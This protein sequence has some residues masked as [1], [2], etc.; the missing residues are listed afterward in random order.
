MRIFKKT[1][2]L[3]LQKRKVHGATLSEYQHNYSVE[4]QHEC[5]WRNATNALFS[6]DHNIHHNLI[7]GNPPET[8]D[9]T[10]LM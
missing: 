7:I 2:L 10:H 6:R 3:L 4:K 5:A 9:I 1:T 8:T